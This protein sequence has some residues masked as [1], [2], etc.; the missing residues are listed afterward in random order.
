MTTSLVVYEDSESEDDSFNQTEEQGS[1]PFKKESCKEGQQVRD[2][3]FLDVTSSPHA[4]TANP[5]R[6][7][8]EYHEK[9][10]SSRQL[11]KCF[12]TEIKYYNH[13]AE[14]RDF[15]D[16]ATHLSLPG[17]KGKVSPLQ[18]L[19]HIPQGVFD[20]SKTAKRHCNVPSGVRP[21]I[22]KRQRLVTSVEK[23]DPNNPAEQVH[24]RDNQLLSDVSAK[25]KLYLG[26]KP[27]AAGIP[28]K[29]LMSLEG[30]QGPV[31]KVQWCPMPHLSHLLLSASMD[32]SFK[33][34]ITAY[35]LYSWGLLK[36][37]N[38]KCFCGDGSNNEGVFIEFLVNEP[39]HVQGGTLWP[40][41]CTATSQQVAIFI[42]LLGICLDVHVYIC[43]HTK[44]KLMTDFVYN[45]NTTSLQVPPLSIYCKDKANQTAICKSRNKSTTLVQKT[46]KSCFA[47]SDW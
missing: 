8:L 26:H 45:Y 37:E 16:N 7:V 29:L 3:S 9:D 28:R 44:L 22:P 1:A 2:F 32:K 13:I 47:V 19:P 35:W 39:T 38:D 18:A 41:A 27:A 11:Q 4:S 31:N 42:S 17:T 36:T 21:Y 43:T 30:H 6:T 15:G 25:I 40:L 14:E 20:G 33:V 23:A 34:I 24:T 5:H 12:D 46:L 10:S